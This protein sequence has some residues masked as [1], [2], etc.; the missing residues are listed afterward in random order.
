MLNKVV[1]K[2]INAPGA[3]CLSRCRTPAQSHVSTELLVWRGCYPHTA[4]SLALNR[5]T[6]TL[7][8]LI[9]HFNNQ[10][11]LT[12]ALRTQRGKLCLTVEEKMWWD[13]CIP[14]Q[15]ELGQTHRLDVDVSLSVEPSAGV[16]Q[17]DEVGFTQSHRV[18]QHRPVHCRGRLTEIHISHTTCM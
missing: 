13:S 12:A 7:L 17:I 9:E 4:A 11:I 1:E 18:S 15:G 5:N 14:E 10:F 16:P 3:F 6:F 2:T 8:R